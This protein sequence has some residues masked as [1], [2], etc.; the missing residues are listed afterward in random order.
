LHWFRWSLLNMA[1]SRAASLDRKSGQKKIYA[2][3][4]LTLTTRA[5]PSFASAIV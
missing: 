2:R 5:M 1:A 3:V 4:T